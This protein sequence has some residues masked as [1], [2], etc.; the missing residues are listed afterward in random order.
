MSNRDATGAALGEE[1][2]EGAVSSSN[3]AAFRLRAAPP[4]VTRLSRK[5]LAVI[6]VVV[7]TG[8]GGSLL[9]ALHG[10]RPPT[11]PK[12]VYTRMGAAKPAMVTEAPADYSKVPKLGPPLPGDLGPPIVAAQ[13]SGTIAERPVTAAST[14]AQVAQQRQQLE[15]QEREAARTSRLFESEPMASAAS[16]SGGVPPVSSPSLA[17]APTPLP[18]RPQESEAAKRGFVSTSES[19]KFASADRLSPPPS[20]YV[21]QA[22]S[23]IPAALITG[24]RSDLPGQITAQVTENVYDSPTGRVLLI[25]QGSRLIGRYDSDVSA[26]DERVLLA[27]DRLILPGGRS[28]LLDREPGADAAGMAGLQDRT[29]HHWGNLFKA[30]L[31]STLLGVGTELVTDDRSRLVQAL[32][33]GTQDTV[34]QTGRTLVQHEVGLAPTITIRPGFALRVIVTRDLVLE[35]QARS[36]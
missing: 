27:W 16:E 26:G 22:G 17:V 10:D 5:A 4:Q 25:P 29:D 19:R 28:I 18:F 13:R 21:L 24:I 31:I 1:A 6:G 8:I 35:P 11:P 7:G 34:N 20:P 23:V 36:S 14:D 9:Y 3:P 30:S 15:Q 33:Y 2:R 12:N 32:R